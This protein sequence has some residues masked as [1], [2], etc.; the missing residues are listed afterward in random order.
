MDTAVPS[1]QA[2]ATSESAPGLRAASQP[3]SEVRS[4]STPAT[5][6]TVPAGVGTA[7]ESA[8]AGA[9]WHPRAGSAGGGD[10]SRSSSG[11]RR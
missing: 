5:A 2:T 7:T 11:P 8:S 4:T 3:A 6:V 1:G 10:A 9:A